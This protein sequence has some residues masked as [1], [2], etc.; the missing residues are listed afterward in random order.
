MDPKSNTFKA[1]VIG[2]IAAGMLILY[3]TTSKGKAR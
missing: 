2:L 3:A 1:V